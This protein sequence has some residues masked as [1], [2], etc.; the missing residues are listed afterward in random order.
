LRPGVK[1]HDGTTMTAEDVKASFEWA[2]QLLDHPVSA[3]GYMNELIGEIE[4]P[5]ELELIIHLQKPDAQIFSLF[6]G[7][8]YTYWMVHS[9][10]ELERRGFPTTLIPLQEPML[11]GTGPWQYVSR[12]PA[13]N[14]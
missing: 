4:T 1:M 8:L 5:S 2:D 10:A 12:T 11:A 3:S 6:I 14:I 9:K 13:E 7:D